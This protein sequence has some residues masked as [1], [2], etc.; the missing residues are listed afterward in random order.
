MKKRTLIIHIV[1]IAA[2]IFLGGRL[3][4]S[5]VSKQGKICV[6]KPME[7][8]KNLFGVNRFAADVQ[9]MLF[10]N[11]CGAINSVNAENA[12]IIYDKVKSIISNNPDF[13]QAYEVGSLMLS[14]ESPEKAVEIL[15]IA[16]ENPRLKE[17]WK[18]PFLAGF[19]V[20]HHMK[21]KDFTRAESF[22]QKAVSRCSPPEPHVVSALMRAK[23][24]KLL[25]R[26]NWK[27]IPV[28]SDKQ[29]LLCTLIDV[30]MA[31]I[32]SQ[33]FNSPSYNSPYSSIMSF[34]KVSL[35]EKILSTAQSLKAEE[36]DNPNVLPTIEK[37]KAELFAG[38][39]ICENCLTPYGP[40]DKY[41]SACGSKVQPYGLCPKCGA[42]KKGAFCSECGAR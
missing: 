27:G 2:S 31:N 11:Y 38:A 25:A 39:H 28:T 14:V 34:G 18:L 5:L 42:V 24:Q 12:P 8:K 41:C 33:D 15:Q 10:V 23:A 21:N 4:S 35:P 3:A 26:K 16:C 20:S 13:E 40:G 17:N 32:R 36:K 1:V 30:H 37:M 22:F 6:S 19:I 7:S 9:W 29:A